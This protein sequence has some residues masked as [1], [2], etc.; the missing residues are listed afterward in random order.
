MNTTSKIVF[1]FALT[2][3]LTNCAESSFKASTAVQRDKKGSINQSPNEVNM[4]SQDLEVA[5]SAIGQEPLKKDD[6]PPGCT[7]AAKTNI[8]F[9]ATAP[10]A[11][12]GSAFLISNGLKFTSPM[13]VALTTRQHEKEL[14]KSDQ[15]WKCAKNSVCAGSP[16]HNRLADAASEAIVGRRVLASVSPGADIQTLEISFTSPI[17]S[18]SFDMIDQDGNE[19][20]SVVLFDDK[21]AIL[22]TKK[23]ES[24]KG[25]RAS[26]TGNGKPMRIAFARDKA[27]IGGLRVI[28]SKKHGYFGFAF[29]NFDI[30][31]CPAV[32]SAP[33]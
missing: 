8:D 29:D 16:N 11:F 27:E 1:T 3:V 6:N 2:M 28:G 4:E 10:G 25:Y 31:A 12:D 23:L 26:K 18:G 14:A 22:E 21:G 32:A 33:K 13:R 7:E 15:V 20:W 19:S 30:K 5:T 9:E 17:A 24:F